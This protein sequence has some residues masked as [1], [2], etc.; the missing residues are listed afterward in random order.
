MSSVLLGLSDWWCPHRVSLSQL[1]GSWESKSSACSLSLWESTASLGWEFSI[2]RKGVGMQVDKKNNKR[3]REL[4]G[5]LC[6]CV[7]M[8][9][10]VQY[11]R[12]VYF[13]RTSF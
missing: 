8:D 10:C 12:D 2:H 6:V 1:Q 3:W 13:N 7:C 11:P 9:V 5:C 4:P